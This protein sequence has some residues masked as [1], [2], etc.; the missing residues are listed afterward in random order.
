MINKN[1]RLLPFR[2]VTEEEYNQ[3]IKGVQQ[4]SM[5][6]WIAQS[7]GT[8]AISC[9]SFSAKVH[10]KISSLLLTCVCSLLRQDTGGLKE[11]DVLVPDHYTSI[12]EAIASV[13]NNG[14]VYIRRGGASSI[15]THMLFS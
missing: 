6:D 12:P 4:R 15:I 13:T 14:T 11:G 3:R 10:D 8:P 1:D 2:Q 5:E 9:F 7:V